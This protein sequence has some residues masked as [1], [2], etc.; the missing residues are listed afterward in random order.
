MLFEE[1]DEEEKYDGVFACA[2]L[3]HVR[4]DDLPDILN[5]V[6]KALKKGGIAYVSFKYGTFEGYRSGRYFTDLN[7]EK[8]LKLMSE[9]DG[10]E[11][12]EEKITSDVRPGREKEKWLNAILKKI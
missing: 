10:L 11:V 7:E 2:S 4:Y 9:C 3:L 5:R 6:A 8:F 1:L 12:V